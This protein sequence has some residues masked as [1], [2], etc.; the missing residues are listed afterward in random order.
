MK[1]I[2]L[3]VPTNLV[4]LVKLDCIATSVQVWVRMPT[5]ICSIKYANM[6]A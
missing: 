2:N 4:K 6:D 1:L 5:W 3:V